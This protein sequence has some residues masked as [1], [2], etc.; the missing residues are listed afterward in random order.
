MPTTVKVI[1]SGTTAEL[2]LW[3][4]GGPRGATSVRLTEML[5][6]NRGLAALG[7]VLPLGTL[8]T[9]PDLPPRSEIARQTA[10]IV[11]LFD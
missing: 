8:V 10:P 1:R 3:K 2:L 5:E 11:S 9:I 4:H 6:M 7:P